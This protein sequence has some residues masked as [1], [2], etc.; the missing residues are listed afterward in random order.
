MRFFTI[1]FLATNLFACAQN[2]S[3][4]STKKNIMVKQNLD[5]AI[6]AGGCFWCTEAIF[7]RVNGV[8]KVTSGYIGGFIKN[9]SYEQV[10]N[11][12][13][14]HA[15]ATQILF[16][17]AIIQF[18]DLLEIFWKTHDPTTLNKQG[19]DVGT[20][21]RSAIFYVNEKQKETATYYKNELDKS[22]IYHSPIITEIVPATE[23]Y[24]AENYH[25]NYY[26]NNANQGDRKSVV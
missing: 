19:N 3:R 23:F 7:Q 6:F 21:Y 2:N 20:Q 24:P 12:N 4:V 26:N 8:E 16:D 17:P 5:T 13:T 9:P 18:K 11:K 14:G 15:E 1:L 25:Q 22:G 10:C